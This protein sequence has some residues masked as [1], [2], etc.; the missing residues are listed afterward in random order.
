VLIDNQ[1]RRIR[2]MSDLALCGHAEALLYPIVSN[3]SLCRIVATAPTEVWEVLCCCCCCLCVCVC[4]FVCVVLMVCDLGA[5]T[6]C[7]VVVGG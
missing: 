1:F 2:T 3:E 5:T 7:V 6:R 4:L